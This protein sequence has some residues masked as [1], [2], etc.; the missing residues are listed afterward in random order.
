MLVQLLLEFHSD[1]GRIWQGYVAVDH[2]KCGMVLFQLILESG[3]DDFEFQLEF[4][5]DNRPTPLVLQVNQPGRLFLRNYDC[6]L[7]S[8]HIWNRCVFPR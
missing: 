6:S 8:A 4:A 1:V 5:D 3:S 7:R 2:L